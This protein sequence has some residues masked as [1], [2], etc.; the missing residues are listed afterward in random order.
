MNAEKNTLLTWYPPE[1]VAQH[2]KNRALVAGTPYEKYLADTLE[3]PVA[4]VEALKWAPLPEKALFA[5][6]R[7]E[8]NRLFQQLQPAGGRV[9]ALGNAE[10]GRIICSFSRHFFPGATARCWNGGL[11]GIWGMTS[12]TL[13]GPPMPMSGTGCPIQNGW[14]TQPKPTPKSSM[15][16]K[17]QPGGGAHRRPAPE[18]DYPFPGSLCPGTYPG[19]LAAGRLWL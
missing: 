4:M 19:N 8:L 11:P 5:P 10:S 3:V 7:E 15:T 6:T 16:R 9:R 1:Y 18:C 2:Q 13:F 12:A 17:S 14:K